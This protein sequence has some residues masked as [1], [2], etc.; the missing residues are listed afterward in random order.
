M[1][2]IALTLALLGLAGTALADTNVALNGSVSLSGSGF[3]D[4]S[5][6]CCGALAAASTVTDGVF[7]AE[8]AQ[9][10]T[11]SVFWTSASGADSITV[12]LNHAA[13]V[14]QVTLQADDNDDYKI[15]YRDNANVWHDATVISP[16][17]NY[18]LE[19]TSATLSPI[20]ATA[21]RITGTN[22]DGMY[23]VSE[24][25]A[26]GTVSTVPEPETYALL[27]AGLGLLGYMARRKSRR[28]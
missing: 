11:N 20:L 19:T 2:K 26:T 21:F 6:W 24:F 12:S 22:G 3:G 5:G 17:R 18:G 28:G 9:W 4:S 15:E 27:S 1:K 25:Q 14:N 13:W 8:N 16:V 23:A 7:L 10:N